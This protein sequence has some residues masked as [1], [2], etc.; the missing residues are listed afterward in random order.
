MNYAVFN[1]DH[2][3]VYFETSLKLS[4]SEFNIVAQKF[5]TESKNVQRQNICCIDYL[6]F[7]TTNQ[8][9][10]NDDTYLQFGHRFDQSI[11]GDIVVA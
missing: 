1:L 8:L 5:S 3:R 6:T 4:I 7:Q 10:Q 9:S 11:L 2:N